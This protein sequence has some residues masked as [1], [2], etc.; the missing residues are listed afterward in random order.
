MPLA[1]TKLFRISITRIVI[2]ILSCTLARTALAQ[3]QSEYAG[4]AV[5]VSFQ[6]QAQASAA[7]GISFQNGMY[8]GSGRGL[9]VAFGNPLDPASLLGHAPHSGFN[10]D[11]VNTATGNYI[12]ERTDISIPGRGMPFEF[13]R[14]YNSQDST[15]G[16][17]GAGW[18][19]SYYI[20]LSNNSTSVS[21]R[22]EDGHIDVFDLVNG[23]YQPHNTGIYDQL[24]KNADGTFTVTQKDQKKFNFSTTGNL[25]SIA[26]RN[27]NTM[28]LAY[29]GSGRLASVQDTGG[30]TITFSY[31]SSSRIIQITDPMPRN[32]N[33]TYDANNNLATSSDANGGVTQYT[34]DTSHKMLTALDP[35]GNTFLTNVYD[36]NNRVTQQTDAKNNSYQFAYD[37]TTGQ[38]TITDP[39]NRTRHGLSRYPIAIDSAARSAWQKLQLHL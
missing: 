27:N 34:Y 36:A 1:A 32:I 28:M 11:P 8:P 31:D 7:V 4:A 18:T 16:P 3:Q 5:S 17:L 10:A 20:S 26:D 21:L 6:N 33:F 13:K 24:V 38:T 29:D 37:M 30:R 22:W 14:F 35:R 12:F 9:T 23:S 15:T 19:H 39:L 2:L 25:T